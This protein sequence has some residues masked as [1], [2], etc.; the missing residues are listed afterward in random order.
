MK[1]TTREEWIVVIVMLTVI[2]V[3]CLW[4]IDISL[5]AMLTSP[6]AILTNGWQTREPM[7]MYHLGLYGCLIVTSVLAL[8]GIHFIYEGKNDNSNN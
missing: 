8:I 4:C 1:K 2:N 3:M 7:L 6:N 5:S